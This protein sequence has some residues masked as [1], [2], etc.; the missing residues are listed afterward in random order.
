MQH[1]GV[2]PII[3]RTGLPAAKFGKSESLSGQ[4]DQKSRHKAKRLAD[5]TIEQHLE[6]HFGR[7]QF[8]LDAAD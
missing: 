1:P 2:L 4:T 7:I 3:E 5:S 6:L 8:S